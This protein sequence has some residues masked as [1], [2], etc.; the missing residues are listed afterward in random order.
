MLNDMPGGPRRGRLG[1]AA[2]VALVLADE[3]LTKLESRLSWQPQRELSIIDRVMKLGRT[4]L[5]LKELEYF[6]EARE[7]TLAE[8]MQALINRLLEPLEMHWLGRTQTG[9]VNA[10]VKALRMK[11][12]PEMVQNHLDAQERDRRWRMLADLQLAQQRGLQAGAVDRLFE[13]FEDRKSV[14]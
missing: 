5:M 12:M 13:P 11:I 7:G 10:R 9:F 8:R 1:Y 2:M 3:L 6:G 4:L 14:V